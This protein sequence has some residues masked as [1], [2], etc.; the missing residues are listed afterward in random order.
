[1]QKKQFFS[2]EAWFNLH[3]HMCSQNYRYY[4][5]WKQSSVCE[6]RQYKAP[7][8]GRSASQSRERQPSEAARTI[9]MTLYINIYVYLRQNTQKNYG[10][11]L[12]IAKH[13]NLFYNKSFYIILAGLT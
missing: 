7:L 8:D 4:S 1:M 5:D 3:G 6:Q 9:W 2:D 12:R 11:G 13:S 10:I